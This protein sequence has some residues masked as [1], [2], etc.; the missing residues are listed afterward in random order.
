M[1]YPTPNNATILTMYRESI[2][3]D[4][5]YD[6]TDIQHSSAPDRNKKVGYI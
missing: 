4:V 3:S 1:L 2:K 5:L 6:H